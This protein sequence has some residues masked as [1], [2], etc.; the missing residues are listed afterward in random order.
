MSEDN[1]QVGAAAFSDNDVKILDQALKLAWDRFLKTGM[2]NEHN[3]A[4]SQQLIAQRILDSARAGER[5]A[6]QL[7]R[8]ALFHLW[9]VKFTGKPLIKV[10]PRRLRARAM[11][12]L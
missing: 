2:M 9:S 6:G 3:M 11:R 1:S 4:E 10:A 5:D 8:D 12:R 7:A